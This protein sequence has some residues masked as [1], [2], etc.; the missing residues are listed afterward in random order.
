MA[1][2]GSYEL[3][4]DRHHFASRAPR[5][6]HAVR[7]KQEKNGDGSF[8]A[9]AS[10]RPRSHLLARVG[11]LC[12]GLLPLVS[13]V[14]CPRPGYFSHQGPMGGVHPGD[15]TGPCPPGSYCPS[16]ATAPLPC[17]VGH[18]AP[19][20][21]MSACTICPAEFPCAS[22]GLSS[23]QPDGGHSVYAGFS[24]FL[25]MALWTGLL[26][27]VIGCIY[28]YR[29]KHLPNLI[30]RFSLGDAVSPGEKLLLACCCVDVNHSRGV[31]GHESHEDFLET[32]DAEAAD[33]DLDAD[34]FDLLNDD[35]WGTSFNKP[36]G[37]GA[38]ATA[39]AAF[40]PAGSGSRAATGPL[41]PGARAT[42]PKS[43]AAASAAG[44]PHFFATAHTSNFAITLAPF[45]KHAPQKTE[46]LATPQG[47]GS[48]RPQPLPPATPS[49]APQRLGPPPGVNTPAGGHDPADG[50]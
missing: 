50:L 23:Y 44:K 22:T 29:K 38:S 48:G 5:N 21:A 30:Y 7:K 9:L 1:E 33:I 17:A 35:A 15:C 34:N 49:P 31:V 3:A 42:T 19:E 41:T 25:V 40:V 37:G 2:E 28:V 4:A 26:L 24:D 6:F 20:S 13:A 43:S 45:E 11:V 32:D 8:P 46:G 12:L 14:S 36:K 18:Y 16:G 39:S 10:M 47:A 27:F